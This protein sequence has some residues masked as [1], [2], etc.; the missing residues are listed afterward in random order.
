MNEQILECSARTRTDVWHRLYGAAFASRYYQNLGNGFLRWH[1][2]LT[3]GI[4]FLGGGAAIPAVLNLIAGASGVGDAAW[5]LILGGV[6]GVLL[7]VISGI[8]VVGDFARKSSG[9]MLISISCARIEDE[10]LGLLSK[11]DQYTI[12]DDEAREK[13]NALYEQVRAETYGSE[14][15]GIVTSHEDSAFRSA[16]EEA[17]NY[18]EVLKEAYA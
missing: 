1:R 11:I 6:A 9:A 16:E 10:L 8:V 15:L 5:T 7:A 18:M 14:K 12:S 17:Y 13:M 2:V 3:F 4:L